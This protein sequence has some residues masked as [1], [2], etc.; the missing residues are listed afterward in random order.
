ML[1][2]RK[3]K[4]PEA[5]AFCRKKKDGKCLFSDEKC[6]WNHQDR[7]KYTTEQVECYICNQTFKDKP[8]MMTHRKIE[9]RSIKRKCD[10]FL[11]N[12]CP[13]QSDACWYLHKLEEEPMEIDR[14]K[15]EQS[16]TSVF[17]NLF[18]NTK[19]P[20]MKPKKN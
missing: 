20:I 7:Q 18:M 4:H 17:R 1:N 3:E 16:E 5:V 10:T 19:P 2:H 12:N 14:E 15:E 11:Q 13:F 8:S 9:H 6:W